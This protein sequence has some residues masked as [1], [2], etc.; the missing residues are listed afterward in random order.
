MKEEIK[1]LIKNALKNLN[2]SQ[3]EFTIEHPT[4]FSHGDYAVNVAIVGAKEA[5]KNPQEL[6]SDI[7]AELENNLP[8]TIEKVEI[9]GPGFLNFFLSK[10]FFENALKRVVN[11]ENEYG[12]NT[13][14][15]DQKIIFEYTDL[16][17]FKSFHIGHLMP[18]A[19]GEALARL[20]EANGAEVKRANYQGDIGLHVAKAIWGMK[21]NLSA[22]PKDDDS[23]TEKVDFLG[24]SYSFGASQYEKDEEAKNEIVE[25][26]KKLFAK[27]DN[28]LN[29]LYKKG[30]EW[31]LQ[32][33]EILYRVLGTTFDYYLFESETADI[34]KKIV[35]EG[36]EKGIFEKS[37]EAI[38]YK[39]E[40]KGLHTRVFLTSEGLPTYE[41]K[42]LGLARMKDD[43]FDYDKSV[44][45]TA[46][47]QKEYF[48]VVFAAMEEMMPEIREKTEHITFGLLQLSS[49]KMSSRLGNVITASSLIADV[50]KKVKE[51]M[52]GR[53]FDED[54][55]DL[56]ALAVTVGA[57]KYSILKQTPGKNIVFDFEKSI[58]FEGDSGP[59]L[60][61]THTRALSVLEKAKGLSL[62]DLNVK[63]PSDW[64]VT[65]LEKILYQM[66][67][68]IK[69]SFE[70]RGP[71]KLVKYLIE[72][73]AEF[74]SF[75]GNQKIVDENDEHSAYRVVIT[76]AV[77]TII[78]NGL[79]ILG[80]PVPS[81]M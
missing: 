52:S 7:K 55:K 37:E 66:P 77:A 62:V 63:Q 69:D 2:L 46:N 61:Y 24:S 80:I 14:L 59:Y 18:N 12:K 58:S 23:L 81:K 5:G 32:S 53:D 6:A 75:Y 28:E 47:E 10:K 13:R 33:F 68:V 31:S 67:E 42:D 16:N 36:L 79:Y 44:I 76:H 49:G 1:K 45:I 11:E 65:N 30:K 26:N 70:D 56:V 25:I 17:P 9:A 73:S 4:D 48:K 8:E 27:S 78:K 29:E 34:G 54:F 35:E 38:V 41:A 20:A 43:K 60:Q 39:G 22:L 50:V 19:I 21:Q 3:I 72:V 51:K 74:N 40:K 71:Q 15:K 57:I 64:Q